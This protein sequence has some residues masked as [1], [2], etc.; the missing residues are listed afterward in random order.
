ML[1]PFGGTLCL[2]KNIKEAGM[3][4]VAYSNWSCSNEVETWHE[5]GRVVVNSGK[6]VSSC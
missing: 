1:P 3:K 2:L 4:A 6:H 5:D